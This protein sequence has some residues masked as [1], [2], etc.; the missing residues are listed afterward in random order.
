MIESRVLQITGYDE[1]EIEIDGSD[2]PPSM[3]VFPKQTLIWDVKDVESLTIND[4]TILKYVSPAPT[5]VIVGLSE[6]KKFPK[7][8]RA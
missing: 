8:I 4:F 6:P 7:D 1:H 2:Y 3:I 5:Y